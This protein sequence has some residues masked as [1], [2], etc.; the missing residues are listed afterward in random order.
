M[1]AFTRYEQWR[2]M[3]LEDSDLSEELIRLA[4]EEKEIYERFYT[5]LTFGTAG[6][7]G[8]IGAGTNCM[9]IYT[10]RRA[11]QGIC[12][13]LHQHK[14]GGSAAIA[15]DSRNKS[16]LFAEATACVF[17][18]NGVKVYLYSQLT[19]TPMLS[20]AVRY[21]GC[22]T[23]VVV[24]A[25]HNPAEYNGYK[26]YDDSGC[27]IASDM[28]DGIF[29]C[30]LETDLFTGVKTM[31]YDDAVKAGL[32][33]PVDDAAVEAYFQQV[34]S[35]RCFSDAVQ[36]ADLKLV[37]TPL[38]GAGNLPVRRI[39]SEIGVTDPILVQQQLEPDGNFPTCRYPNPEFKEALLLGLKLAEETQADILIGTDPD[40]D[41]VGMAV[42]HNAEYVQLGGN[43]VGVLLAD[44]IAHAKTVN[45]TM[46]ERPV[47]IKSIVTTTLTDL[48]ANSYGIE[49][50]DV[51]TGFKNIGTEIANLEAAGEI[52]R[53]IFAYEESCGYLAG[54]YVRDKDAVVTAML[55]AEM[56]A[57]YK[58]AGK[59]LVDVMNDIYKRFGYFYNHVTN[60]MF[61]GADGMKQMG[62]IMDALFAAP[63][64][65]LA[66]YAVAA[67]C[68]YRS[69][70]CVKGGER[71]PTGLPQSDVLS[72][73]L[74]DGNVVVI[75][76][77][78]TEPKLKT[79]YI[80]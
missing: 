71:F 43:D 29:E 1:D 11:T 64:K 67:C 57:Y 40:A 44:Y 22:D 26:A 2:G 24:T 59:T 3:P 48:V 34:L 61:A 49:V 72:L 55:V 30:I 62:E 8:K 39:L 46:P 58:K 9:N 52:E 35:C 13:W 25:S 79:Y 65:S 80:V 47:M 50:R 14:E 74:A 69:G 37:Y 21:Y 42:R 36:G 51:L 7:R 33:V 6:L 28:A 18:A 16:Q 38:N 10:V 32:I 17:A 75:R 78:G 76:P 19:P 54:P 15:Y 66:D 4:G 77:S 70:V 63:P 60:T 23:G 68:D 5:D 12:S 45:K 53:F 73:T 56:A 27:Q 20:W 41:R 31:A